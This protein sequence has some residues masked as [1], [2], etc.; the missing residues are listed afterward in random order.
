MASVSTRSYKRYCDVNH[1]NDHIIYDRTCRKCNKLMRLY[2]YHKNKNQ[3][4][5]C[6]F[7]EEMIKK[8]SLLMHK[9]T[10]KHIESE[11]KKCLQSV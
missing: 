11:G 10:R 4:I 1:C 2:T 3:T 6:D 7:C 9:N 5:Y 8:Y